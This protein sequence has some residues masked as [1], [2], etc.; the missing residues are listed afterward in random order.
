MK[1]RISVRALI[2]EEEYF[3][4]IFRRKQLE[5]KT[6]K[7]YYTIPGGGLEGKESLE[8]ALKREIKEEMSVDIKIEGYI[9]SKNIDQY[10]SHFFKSKIISGKPRLGKIESKRS[11]N[12]NIYEIRKV[13]INEIDNIDIYFKDIILK[14][15]NNEFIE[16]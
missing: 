9:G 3:Y 4:T 7:E 11:S 10:I 2:F 13:S 6:F 14:A 8:E 15:Y 16:L 12:T 5:D 1:Q